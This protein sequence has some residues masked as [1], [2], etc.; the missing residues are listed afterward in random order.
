[1]L[2]FFNPRTFVFVRNFLLKQPKFVPN[3]SSEQSVTNCNSFVVIHSLG[4]QEQKLLGFVTN[5]NNC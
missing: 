3:F 1:M 2:Q 5:Y 4:L